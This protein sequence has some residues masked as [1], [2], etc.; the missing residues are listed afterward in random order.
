VCR[1][2]KADDDLFI[3]K[4]LPVYLTDSVRVWLDHL[5][6]DVIDS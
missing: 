1:A 6:R 4:F 5:L 3:I 2:G